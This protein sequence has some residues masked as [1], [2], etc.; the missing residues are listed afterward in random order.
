MR[1]AHGGNDVAGVGAGAGADDEA[2]ESDAIRGIGA[3][4]PLGLWKV[5]TATGLAM[6]ES[7][8]AQPRVRRG[9]RMSR[10]VQGRRLSVVILGENH[11]K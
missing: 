2:D 11:K 10:E 4:S 9:L 7:R 6:S 3:G 1:N 5:C 8:R